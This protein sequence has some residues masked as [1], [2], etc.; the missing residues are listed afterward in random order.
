MNPLAE[1]A[2]VSSRLPLVVRALSLRDVER[3]IGANVVVAADLPDPLVGF[4]MI[5]GASALWMSR[6]TESVWLVAFAK[7][8]MRAL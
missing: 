5:G 3:E 7:T 2:R 4:R 6:G 1:S 8:E